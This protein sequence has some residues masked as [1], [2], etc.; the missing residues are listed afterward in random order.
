MGAYLE[1]KN[2][3]VGI[4]TI[5]GRN[6]VVDIDHFRLE[7]GESF[8]IVGESGSGKTILAQSILR[9]LPSPPK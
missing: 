9:I 2:L 8:R 4:D 6:R 3:K 5:E 1:I 7:K